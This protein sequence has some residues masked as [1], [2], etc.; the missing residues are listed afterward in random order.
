MAGG[1]AVSALYPDVYAVVDPVQDYEETM[2][3]LGI[4]ATAHEARAVADA[5]RKYGAEQYP[6]T[7]TDKP[8]LDPGRTAEVQHWQ[9]SQVIERWE[10]REDWEA[11]D[12]NEG[13]A[14][15]TLRPWTK[16]EVPRGR[17]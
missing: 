13:R 12:D 2:R 8:Y 11:W 4:Y 15:Y 3:I 7:P 10:R 9:G 16:V 1:A 17:V 5:A 6:S 14:I